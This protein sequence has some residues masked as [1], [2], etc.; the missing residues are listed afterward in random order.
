MNLDCFQKHVEI[1]NE[2]GLYFAMV[3]MLMTGTYRQVS[4]KLL[5]GDDDDDDDDDIR[6]IPARFI[7]T[8]G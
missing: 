6:N 2:H 4:L 7:Q 5:D 1:Y 3:M 8:V